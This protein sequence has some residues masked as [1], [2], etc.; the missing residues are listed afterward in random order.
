METFGKG[1]VQKVFPIDK[2]S[3]AYLKITTAKYY[4]PS[5]RSIQKEDYKKDSDVFTNFQDSSEYNQKIDYYTK[6]GRVVH[7][8]GGVK[9]D[10]DAPG[11]KYDSFLYSL[12]SRGYLFTFA[13]DYL[14]RHPEVKSQ[15]RITITDEIIRE[16]QNCVES[17]N[18]TFELEGENELS[19]FLETAQKK[20][21]DP[22]IQDLVTVALQKL[23]NEKMKKFQTDRETVAQFLE[24]EMAEQLHGNVAR[25]RVMLSYDKQ[26][27]KAVSVLHDMEQY[28]EIL[29]IHK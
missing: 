3:Q 28:Q 14:T 10:V 27:K 24:A 11:K 12:T 22:D 16:F 18:F 5:G 9:P 15:P 1:L 17:K 6:N 20:N 7:G 13:V 23:R 25:I 21:Y 26:V 19:S 29:A 4:I 8:G 2:V